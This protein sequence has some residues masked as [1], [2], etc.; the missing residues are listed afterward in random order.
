MGG[1][2]RAAL[3]ASTALT[4]SRHPASAQDATWRQTPASGNYNAGANWSSG[5][6]PT[7]TAFFGASNRT[8]LSF[9]NNMSVGGWTFNADAGSY[10]FTNS[11]VIT[12]NG[13]GII[14]NGGSASINNTGEMNF[15]NSSTAG[16]ATIS[17]SF[18]LDFYGSSSAGRA[19]ITNNQYLEFYDNS[20]AGQATITNNGITLNFNNSSTAGS[21][22]ILNL[23]LLGFYD[24]SKAGTATIT[25]KATLAFYDNSS[26]ENATIINGDSLTFRGFS[27]AGTATITTLMGATTQFISAGKSDGA[28]F[29]TEAGGVLDIS[30]PTGFASMTAG[31]IEG[32]GSH[33]I[34]AKTFTVG[35]ND[36]STEVSGVISG[37][38]GALVKVGA[39]TLTLSGDNSYTGGTTISGGT[40]QLGNG[41]ATGSILGNIV[42]NG[43][44]AFNRGDEFTFANTISG[45][46]TVRQAGTGTLVLTGSNSYGGGTVIE[47]GTL[48]VSADA[49]LG[50]ASGGLTLGGGTLATTA[51]FVSTRTV[52]LTTG[53]GTFDVSASTTLTLSGA[54]G[55]GGSLTKTGDGMLMLT[56]TNTYEGG[57]I[58]NAGTLQ[59]AS[60]GAFVG[61]TAYQV[62]GG[63]LDLNGHDLTMASLSGTGGTVALGSAR[64]TIDQ[65]ANTT[66]AGGIEGTGGLTKTGTGMLTLTSASSY[67]GDT[68]VSGGTLRFGDGSAGGASSLGGRLTVTAGELA[69]TA[70]ATLSIAQAVD[71]QANT[72][73]SIAPAASGPSLEAASLTIGSGV[74]FNLSGITSASQL[75][76]VLIDTTAGISGDFATV[77]VGGFSGT[78]DY[79]TLATRKSD[80][81]KQYLASHGLSWTA[82]NSLAHGTFTLTDASNSFTVG[83]ALNDQAANAA[84]GWDGRTL[85]KA[86]A[87]TLILTADNGYT[88]GTVIKAGTLQIGD[89]G[90]TGSVAGNILNDGR[91]VFNRSDTLSFAGTIAG[92]GTLRQAGTGTLVLTGNNSYAGGTEFKAGTIRVSS[93]AN[94]GAATGGLTFTGGTLATT[95]S[96]DTGRTVQLDTAGRFDVAANTE[97]GLTGGVTG[98]GDLVKAGDGTLRLDNMTNGYGNTLVAAGTLIGHA[99][100]ISGNIGNAGTV[101]FDQAADA[102]FAG[103]IGTLDGVAGTMVKRGAGTLTLTGASALDWA[104]AAGGLTTAAERFAGH[105][106]IA[107]GATL[108]FDQ[109]E[110]AAYA[111]SLSGTGSFTKTG[112]A[113]LVLTGDSSGFAGTTM[114]GAG[115]LAINGR[116]GGSLTVASGATLG[117]SGTI[118]SGAGST[119]TVASGGTLAP[120]N[121]IGTLTVDGNLVIAAGA[122]YAVEVDPASSGSD[123][124]R[125]TGS[126]TINGGT[127]VHIGA[128]GRYDLSSTYRILTAGS[129]SGR[130]DAVSSN[131]AYLTPTLGYD[132]TG[133]SLTLAR[134]DTA[135]ASRAATRNQAA[136]AAAIDTIGLASGH[137]VYNAVAQLPDDTALIRRAFDQLSG[138]IHASAKTVLIEDS[139]FVRDA[140]SERLRAAFGDAAASSGEVMA[141]GPQGIAAAPAT[142]DRFALWSQG[143]GAWGSVNGDGNAAR[144][145]RATGGFLIGADG[146]VFDSWRLGILAG[147]SRTSFNS[148]DRAS[149]GASDNY[150]L[151]L[152]GGT[153]LA[154]AGGSLGLRAGIAQ[155]WHALETSR[156]AILPGLADRLKA[157]YGAT[158]FQAFG[159]VGYR[160]E[161]GLA[162]LEPFAN[163][164]YVRFGTD[165]FGEWGGPSALHAGSQ[166]SDTVFTTL[167][168]RASATFHLAGFAATARATLGWRHALGTTLP[169]ASQ[170]F[171]AGEAFTVAGVPIARD[172]ALVET[173]LD[174]A[175]SRAVTLGLSYSGQ[176]A[177]TARQH[178]FKANINVRF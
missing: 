94:L 134:N 18:F 145:S 175:V 15:T 56:G 133:V 162:A 88:G 125:V 161:A 63:R 117:G 102:S 165:G 122:R 5:A 144:L 72:R 27:S 159:D 176:I 173:G 33:V 119:V 101:V 90:T 153:R 114:V 177:R 140:A 65:A 17:N 57:T 147:Y 118:G 171:S 3:L 113:T 91:L 7:G 38:G 142:T 59:A 55:G 98:S 99:G 107:T 70:P 78:V 29:I 127:V 16:T 8:S 19:V 135:F 26:A 40:L 146:A 10:T 160:V 100:T 139:R 166:A 50:A 69:I 9:A 130:F 75:D 23:T 58:V 95:A 126:A 36:S 11:R 82:G 43:I 67:G 151:G 129:L 85:T 81:G 124:V 48:S 13:A 45:S 30:D 116:L 68:T 163:L 158:T 103:T 138:E 42:N 24:T 53:G 132:A 1:L 41:G 156:I 76:R 79:L 157:R 87:G 97:L 123:L 74:T 77:T 61:N 35:S 108:T 164:A 109:A 32:A 86:G 34:G 22:T 111:G 155:T 83:V 115:W 4:I 21:A 49:N 120:G 154:V 136:T 150:H 137:A 168:L 174:M 80:D 2:L 62:N 64:L 6:M 89:G 149:S 112:T 14:I 46:G 170:A 121:S 73:L 104:I 44:L 60:A 47:S 20:S 143:F 66:Y 71:L 128:T 141:Y 167:G 12:F 31:S 92:S 172:A 178:G 169:L 96:F 25:N 84:T 148:R 52:T 93:D 106:A 131:F 110:N 51:S 54:I 105:A 37:N 28:R 152:Y 39:G